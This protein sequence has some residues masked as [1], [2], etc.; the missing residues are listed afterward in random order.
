MTEGP[1]KASIH[2]KCIL[3]VQWALPLLTLLGVL[4]ASSISGWMHTVGYNENTISNIWFLRDQYDILKGRT[5]PDDLR[6]SIHVF[7]LFIWILLIILSLRIVVGLFTPRMF[8]ARTVLDK[9]NLSLPNLFF[10]FLFAALIP[11]YVSSLGVADWVSLPI[12]Q[13][14]LNYSPKL[15]IALVA[16]TFCTGCI[17]LLK[18]YS[19]L[20]IWLREKNGSGRCR[21]SIIRARHPDRADKRQ[22][23]KNLFD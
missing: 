12:L 18:L 16:F 14:P 15:F 10:G 4:F 21:T 20:R 17:F 8:E 9:L 23:Q 22:R 7:E 6:N 2:L 19:S 13:A 5:S 1:P 11:I 3:A